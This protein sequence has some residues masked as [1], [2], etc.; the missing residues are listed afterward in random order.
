MTQ[1][2]EADA[3]SGVDHRRFALI[4]NPIKIS[5][6]LLD[7]IGERVEAG[8]WGEPLLLETTE[9][10]PGRTMTA[11][12]LRAGVETVLAAGGDGTIRVV[13][14]G[15]AGSGVPLGI[16]PEGTANLLSRNLGLPSTE[17]D[18]VDVALDGNTRSLDLVRISVDAD[19]DPDRFAVMAGLGLDAAIMSNTNTAVKARVGSV[20]YV[21]AALQQLGREPRAMRVTVD[22][23][24]PLHRKALITVVGNVGALQGDLE[25]IPG[26]EPDDGLID[27]LVASP[28][29]LR[30]WLA[31]IA[32]LITRTRRSGDRIDQLRGRRV[33]IEVDQ[34][35]EYQLDG[36]T[37]GSCRRLEAVIEPG[38]LT[39][40][41]P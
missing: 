37:I 41:V 34:P 26:A 20:A 1:Q 15:L 5:D 2:S 6:G 40:K 9:D 13:A 31:T 23:R 7:V 29:R 39:V 30:H 11:E 27:V 33:V 10:D 36:D 16:I 14:A 18:A 25:L 17:S 28:R 35:E 3:A 21:V 4:Y 38:A 24:P 12:A 22:D 19:T 8:G 32:R